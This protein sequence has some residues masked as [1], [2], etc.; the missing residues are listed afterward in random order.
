MTT[1]SQKLTAVKCP[2]RLGNTYNLNDHNGPKSSV[3][4]SHSKLH[5][6][7]VDADVAADIQL[8][9][10]SHDA[11]VDELAQAF[12]ELARAQEA[13][14]RYKKALG[15]ADDLILTTK[16]SYEVSSLEDRYLKATRDADDRFKLQPP[17][18]A[19]TKGMLME[20]KL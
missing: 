20:G 8:A 16:S 11:L 7:A 14:A 10:N 13:L 17:A 1:P 2:V 4:D 6:G 19:E 15:Q 12:A 18:V 5:D 9:L 3:W